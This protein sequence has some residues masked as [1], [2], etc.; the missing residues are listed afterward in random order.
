MLDRRYPVGEFQMEP[1]PAAARRAEWIGEIERLPAR[2]RALVAELPEGALDRPYREGGWTGRQVIH[3]LADSHINSYVR[4]RLALTADEPT[5]TPYDEARWADLTDARLGPVS[6]SL[7]LLDSLH[8]RWV[9]LLR[10][11]SEEQWSRRFL[12]P[13]LGQRD[14]I[15]TLAV[16]AWHGRH[17]AGHLEL[18]R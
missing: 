10:S 11:L 16:Y 7:D 14:L 8:T 13:E 18:L 3:H 2:I 6:V 15:T 17:H 12:H 5:I 9:A 1:A 4:F